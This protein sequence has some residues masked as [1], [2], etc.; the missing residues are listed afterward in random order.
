M[1]NKKIST[2]TGTI[3]ITLFTLSLGVIIFLTCDF[4]EQDIPKVDFKI[5]EIDEEEVSKEE[6][7]DVEEDEKE[8]KEEEIKTDPEPEPEPIIEPEF[9]PGFIEEISKDEEIYFL[10][11]QSSEQNLEDLE[12]VHRMGSFIFAKEDIA[13]ELKE[14]GFIE[15]HSKIIDKI[16]PICRF[17]ELIIWPAYLEVGDHYIESTINDYDLE[18][19]K[20]QM[21]RYLGE[22]TLTGE[23]RE[24]IRINECGPGYEYIYQGDFVWRIDLIK[25]FHVFED[26]IYKGREP[27]RVEKGYGEMRGYGILNTKEEVMNFINKYFNLEH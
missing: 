9:E 25:G 8:E 1:F 17:I 4:K 11:L 19:I 24:T 10:G 3:I 26:G 18:T 7:I 15:K 12:G 13:W 21:D 16:G 23:G 27:K 6:P 20:E 14:E 2:V 5:P 22:D